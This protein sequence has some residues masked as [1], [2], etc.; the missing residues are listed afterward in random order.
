MVLR[1]LNS[2]N[3]TFVNGSR[4]SDAVVGDGDVLTFGK[5]AFNLVAGEIEIQCFIKTL[6]VAAFHYFHGLHGVVPSL[7]GH[8]QQLLGFDRVEVGAGRRA[9]QAALGKFQSCQARREP[10]FGGFLR[11]AQ[12]APDVDIPATSELRAERITGD[13]RCACI[14]ECTPGAVD[15]GIEREV[16]VVRERSITRFTGKKIDRVIMVLLALALGYFAFDKFVLDPARDDAFRKSILGEAAD[17]GTS[18]S[19]LGDTVLVTNFSGSHS[20]PTLS[21]DGRTIVFTSVR[22]GDLDIY[23]LNGGA[24]RGTEFETPPTNTLYRNDGAMRFTDVTKRAGVGDTGAGMGVA[25]DDADGDTYHVIISHYWDAGVLGYDLIERWQ[26]DFIFERIDDI[27]GDTLKPEVMKKYHRERHVRA[28]RHNWQYLFGRLVLKSYDVQIDIDDTPVQ[29]HQKAMGALEQ[30]D[31]LLVRHDTDPE[32]FGTAP[33]EIE[34]RI[35]PNTAG[36]IVV[37]IGGIVS[38]RMREIQALVDAQFR[39]ER[40]VQGGYPLD[41]RYAGPRE[42]LLH[43]VF[44]QN[45]GCSHLIVGRDHAGV[46][47]YYGPFDAHNIFNEIPKNALVCQ[48]LCMD[49]T[50][51]CYD[52]GTMASMKTCPHDSKA[53]IADDGQYQGGSRLLLSGT[54]LRKLMQDERPRHMGIAFDVKGKTFRHEE[55]PEYKANREQMPI[56]LRQQLHPAEQRRDRPRAHECGD[57]ARLARCVGCRREVH[58][59]PGPAEGP[60][61]QLQEARIDV[62][63]HARRGHQ[64]HD[65][66]GRNPGQHIQASRNG[67]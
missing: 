18:D 62:A 66:A 19:L 21:P 50:F 38:G 49:W 40:V 15:R 26:A 60:A 22:D 29:I 47:D 14:F 6:T 33:E 8:V 35:T 44:R 61:R 24:L 17:R 56:E 13:R 58:R 27:F 20:Q 36:V 54:M 28:V 52:C 4:I 43:A 30:I 53:V 5:I 39:Q 55:Y 51:Y 11:G 10:Q 34:R 3:G 2:R 41:M 64:S 45:Y 37:H 42:A 59:K 65:D 12:L 25:A 7:R 23:L 48:P 9:C 16:D 57:P 31:E 1:D 63:H 67:L 32:S 46:G